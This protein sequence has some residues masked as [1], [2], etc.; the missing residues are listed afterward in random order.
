MSSRGSEAPSIE[1]LQSAARESRI[2]LD[3][4]IDLVTRMDDI[5]MHTLRTSVLVIGVF[6]S[7]IGLAGPAAVAELSL[8]GLLVFAFGLGL[9]FVS[10]L[11]GLVTLSTS[12]LSLGI[13]DRHRRLLLQRGLDGTEWNELLLREYGRWE[14]EME[15]VAEQNSRWLYYVLWTFSGGIFLLACGTGVMT[16]RVVG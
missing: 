2:V 5:A 4:Q 8:P 10:I 13:S 14:R 7:A 9:L 12:S 15:Q 6:V 1:P 16:I 11:F 3:H